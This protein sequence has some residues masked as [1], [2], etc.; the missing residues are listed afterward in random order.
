[1]PPRSSS[2]DKLS[3]FAKILGGYQKVVARVEF[4]MDTI[5]ADEYV[6]GC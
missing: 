1:M 4:E 3:S 6:K 2:S 5:E